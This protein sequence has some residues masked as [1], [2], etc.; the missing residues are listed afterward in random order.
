MSEFS[1]SIRACELAAQVIRDVISDGAPLDRAYSRQFAGQK[2]APA[3]QAQI[4]R[5]VGEIIR[6]LNFY[7]YLAH[8]S[9]AEAGGHAAEL[10]MAWHAYQQL[11][12]PRWQQAAP[13][14][15]AI[16]AQRLQHADNV[17]VLRDGCPAW[18]DTL[19][20][21]LLG[22]DWPAERAALAQAPKRY[23][24]TNLLKCDRSQLQAQL[25][26]EGIATAVVEDVATA[27]EVTSDAALFR[28]EAFK[29]GWFEQQ[30]AGSQHVADALDVTPGMR[31]IDACAGAGGKTLALAAKMQGKGRLL[32]MDV[33]QW[34]LDNLKERARRAGAHNVETR[35]ISSSKTIKRLKLSADRLLLDVPCSGLGVLKRNPDTKWRDTAARLPVLQALQAQIL[36]SYSRML[37]VD[38]ILVYATCSIMPDENRQQVDNFLSN[39]SNFRLLDDENISPARSGFDGFYLA[40]LQRI[41]E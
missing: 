36:D 27:L 30:D 28:T 24:R 10:L 15:A 40:R 2:L 22:D 39:H 12:V 5:A 6:R 16:L 34:K 25:A 7:C 33:E 14:D 18:L 32:A 20:Q 31:V 17:A 41:A 35:L 11:Q 1:L 4:T 38:G 3:Q 9:L 26:K 13:L 21:G 19:G 29:D 37:K 23:L 8:V